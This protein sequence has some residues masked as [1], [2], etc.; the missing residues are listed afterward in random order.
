MTAVIALLSFVFAVIGWSLLYRQ[1][2]ENVRSPVTDKAE[3]ITNALATQIVLELAD[4]LDSLKEYD[5]LA[6]RR[7]Q[8]ENDLIT[9]Q[10]KKAEIIVGLQKQNEAAS[11]QFMKERR[12][13]DHQTGLMRKQLDHELRV[14]V[15]KSELKAARE[16]LDAEKKFG[17]EALQEQKKSIERELTSVKEITERLFALVPNLEAKLNLKGKA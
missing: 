17:E 16:I 2:T 6:A 14:A 4:K 3:D 12:E 13:I 9:L 10:Q 5:K 1:K 15:E 7:A 11:K 8:L